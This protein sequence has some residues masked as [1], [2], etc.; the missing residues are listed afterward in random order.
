MMRRSL[1][2]SIASAVV[3]TLLAACTLEP[4]YHTPA[5]PVPRAFPQGDAYPLASGDGAATARI[6]WGDFVTD[7]KLRAVITLARRESRDLR[8]AALNIT[9]AR[10]RYRVQRADLLPTVNAAASAVVGKSSSSGVSTSAATGTGATSSVGGGVTTG[11]SPVATTGGGSYRSYSVD[12]GFSAWELD[13]FG[14]IR[15]LSKEALQTYFAT[16]EARRAVEVSLT[17]EVATDY[18]TLAAD[19]QRLVTE[20]DTLKAAEA[21]LKVNQDRFRYGIASELDVRQAETAVENSRS[22]IATYTTQGAQDLNALNLVVGASVPADLLPTGLDDTL[23]ILADAPAG[24]DSAVL[25]QRPDV[26]QAEH[27]LKAYNADIGAARAAF[28]PTLSLTAS[29]GSS[30]IYLDRLFGSGTGA[31][32]FAPNLSIPI[33]DY[34]RNRADLKLSKAQRDSAVASYEQAIQTA[35]REVADALAQRGT[36]NDLIASQ[37]R[38]VNA[39]S[40][41]LKLADARYQRGVDTYLNTLTAQINLAAARQTLISARLTRAANLVALY[42]ALGGGA[43]TAVG[44]SGS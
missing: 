38:L 25:L 18:L 42:R 32:S 3:A 34:G 40:I 13:L 33:F 11:T 2:P 36:V 15:S 37:E 43:D 23:P 7:P 20:R 17:A 30:S 41:S 35:L 4:P 1:R 21:T 27:T 10:A 8:I 28:F 22:A 14:R 12:V 44:L 19:T 5:P 26:L 31:Y 24:V 6:A 16:V 9:E 39:T 29:G